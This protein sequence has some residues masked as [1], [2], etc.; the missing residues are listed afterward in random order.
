M[1]T[2]LCTISCAYSCS[3]SYCSRSS[4]LAEACDLFASIVQSCVCM[5]VDNTLTMLLCI[6]C[7]V[8]LLLL[9]RPATSMLSCIIYVHIHIYICIY[10]Y[11]YTCVCIYIYIYRVDLLLADFF[12][13]V[14]CGGLRLLLHDVGREVGA[15]AVLFK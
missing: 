6:I 3:S 8:E 12:L 14:S 2:S 13:P 11:I 15:H 9:Q 4:S 5:I 1:L 10:I 7:F